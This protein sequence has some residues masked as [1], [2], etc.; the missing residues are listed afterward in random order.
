[1]DTS[2]RL[3]YIILIILSL[4]YYFYVKKEEDKL[5]DNKD[6]I[7]ENLTNGSKII[8][9]SGIVGEVVKID[10]NTCIIVSGDLDRISYFKITIDSIGKI[11]E[12]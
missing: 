11:L 9:E 2:F 3:E 4:S 8:T 6:F 7:K 1:M 10:G 5:R 12:A